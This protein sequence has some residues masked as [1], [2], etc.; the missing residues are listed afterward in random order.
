LISPRAE[1]AKN[2][3]AERQKN[4]LDGTGEDGD[5]ERECPEGEYQDFLK[6]YEEKKWWAD[7]PKEQTPPT[8]G[9]LDIVIPNSEKEGDSDSEDD[10]PPLDEWILHEG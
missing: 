3:L 9:E 1:L 7:K 10:F 2:A 6:T 8:E 5:H 4:A